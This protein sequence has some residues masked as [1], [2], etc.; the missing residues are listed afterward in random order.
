MSADSQLANR[1]LKLIMPTLTRLAR[2]TVQQA[3]AANLLP[4]PAY[5][6]ASVFADAIPGA[7]VAITLDGDVGTV[8]A[9]NI[10]GSYLSAGQR[11]MAI[12]LDPH[13]VVITNT[14]GS[15]ITLPAGLIM[16]CMAATA[17]AGFSFSYHQVTS[18][19]GQFARLFAAIGTQYNIGG[20]AGTSF[21]WPDLRGCV[22]LFLDNM[23]GSDA[24][25]IA[26]AN[27]LGSIIGQ[28]PNLVADTFS[29]DH[30]YPGA[31]GHGHGYEAPVYD[32]TTPYVTDDGFDPGHLHHYDRAVT[33]GDAN[34]QPSI[35][36][37]GV[38]SV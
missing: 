27:T 2:E 20:E 26:A 9:Q 18:R 12:K 16:G 19:T 29:G 31:S 22:P 35:M 36:C 21:R 37:N 7:T 15:A 10:T 3:A 5:R 32:H 6:P 38:I 14:I 23:G 25:R 13:G 4:I 28:G 30:V 11:V 24:G 33:T 8:D 17:P 1:V 34:V